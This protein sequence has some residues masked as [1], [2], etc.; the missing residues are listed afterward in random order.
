[1]ASNGGSFT[2][3]L[4]KTNGIWT[5]W[6]LPRRGHGWSSFL[7]DIEGLSARQIADRIWLTDQLDTGAR[8]L[9]RFNA[10][11]DI[12]S[13]Q[14]WDETKEVWEDAL[15]TADRLSIPSWLHPSLYYLWIPG[16]GIADEMTGKG[17]AEATSYALRTSDDLYAR[18]AGEIA[19]GSYASFDDAKA[20]ADRLIKKTGNQNWKPVFDNKTLRWYAYPLVPPPGP[21]TRGE[22]KVWTDGGLRFWQSGPGQPIQFAGAAPSANVSSLEGLLVDALSDPSID[23]GNPNNP[24]MQKAQAIQAFMNEPSPVSKLEL[25]LQLATTPGDLQT[26][27]RMMRGE[28]PIQQVGPRGRVAPLNPW[29]KRVVEDVFGK[30]PIPVKDTGEHPDSQIPQGVHVPEES[31]VT[32]ANLRE[33]TEPASTLFKAT[34]TQL[35]Q[36]REEEDRRLGAFQL[37]PTTPPK[38]SDQQARETR[39]AERLVSAGKTANRNKGVFTV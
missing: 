6:E 21:A 10:G 25:A 14:H 36:V 1:M 2:H 15:V 28:L 4:E 5:L 24:A 11:K 7:E 9:Y 38:T 33:I 30:A 34:S 39:E 29:L 18:E 8:T 35:S 22:M 37:P 20:E 17:S 16:E 12:T 31:D 13:G 19:S 3:E 26:I 27:S 23:W 32:P